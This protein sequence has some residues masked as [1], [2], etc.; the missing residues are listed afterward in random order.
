M[1]SQNS[2]RNFCTPVFSLGAR[3]VMV[4]TPFKVGRGSKPWGDM[5]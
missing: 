1:L 3:L 2:K 5:A 4:E